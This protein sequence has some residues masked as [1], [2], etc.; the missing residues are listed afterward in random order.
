MGQEVVVL[1]RRSW[2]PEPPKG[3]SPPS[4]LQEEF[5]LK[6]ARRSLGLGLGDEFQKFQITIVRII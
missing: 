3:F 1:E 4:W 5:G 2:S 6:A